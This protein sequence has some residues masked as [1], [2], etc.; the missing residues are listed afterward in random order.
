MEGLVWLKRDIV[1][2]YSVGMAK[3][4]S[5]ESRLPLVEGQNIGATEFPIHIRSTDSSSPS[6]IRFV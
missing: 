6:K 4:A 1:V 2:D 5:V 3:S